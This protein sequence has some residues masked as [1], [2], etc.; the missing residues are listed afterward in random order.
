MRQYN[1]DVSE[2]DLS[3]MWAMQAR[4]Q[5]M[6]PGAPEPTDEEMKDAVWVVLDFP[7]RQQQQGMPP[8]QIAPKLKEHLDHGGSAMVLFFNGADPLTS[9]L[10]DWGVEL[11]PEALAFM[12]PLSSPRAAP[13]TC[14]S[15]PRR[16][17]LSSSST[18]MVTAPS[19]VP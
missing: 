2:K 9:A 10:A 12:S 15:A 11:H 1:F 4:M 8:P 7:D 13:P 5:Q 6:P 16:S 18:I 17:R 3:G 14:S 19:R